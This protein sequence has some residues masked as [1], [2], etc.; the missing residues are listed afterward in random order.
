VGNSNA[1]EGIKQLEEKL[2]RGL[3]VIDVACGSGALTLQ[4]AELLRESGNGGSIVGIDFSPKMIEL[5]NQKAEERK[6]TNLKGQV[7]NGEVF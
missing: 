5:L 1:L 3:K 4:M 6:L 7:M 2:G